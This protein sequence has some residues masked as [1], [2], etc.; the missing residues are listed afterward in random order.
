MDTFLNQDEIA[1]KEIPLFMQ[2]LSSLEVTDILRQDI[3]EAGAS[4]VTLLIKLCDMV[5][6]GENPKPEEHELGK[7]RRKRHEAVVQLVEVM[8]RTTNKDEVRRWLN[9][10]RPASA[11][12]RTALHHVTF[13]RMHDT[14]EFLLG[15]GCDPCST[16]CSPRGDWGGRTF[17]D[18]MLLQKN[19]SKATHMLGLLEEW[20]AHEVIEQLIRNRDA[21]QHHSRFAFEYA[22]QNE[23]TNTFKYILKQIFECAK[24]ECDKDKSLIVKCGLKRNGL[25]LYLS[26]VV[27]D[28]LGL[29]SVAIKAVDKLPKSCAWNRIGKR[30]E[31]PHV[32]K[33]HD[34][35]EFATIKLEE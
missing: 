21:S 35:V 34:M 10:S 5:E 32:C 28:Y 8:N 14:L 18:L 33:A 15:E 4:R 11:N 24:N 12:S 23:C 30:R 2:T 1:Y 6:Y 27:E 26:N 29:W 7:N 13:S 19:D 25:D 3:P 22:F 31:K 9:A 16:T 17:L 20:G